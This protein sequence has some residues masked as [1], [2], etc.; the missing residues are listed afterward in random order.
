MSCCYAYIII[1]TTILSTVSSIQKFQIKL[2]Y[3]LLNRFHVFIQSKFCLDMTYKMEKFIPCPT[4]SDKYMFKNYQKMV[5]IIIITVVKSQKQLKFF[6]DSYNTRLNVVSRCKHAV[7]YFP[8]AMCPPQNAQEHCVTY[9][10][11]Y[12][13]NCI[14]YCYSKCLINTPAS[15]DCRS[16]CKQVLLQGWIYDYRKRV[17]VDM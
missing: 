1:R 10:K 3:K 16:I 15:I 12:L 4:M 2:C 6:D 8:V 5:Y 9:F 7:S 13:S 17:N 14:V 11:A